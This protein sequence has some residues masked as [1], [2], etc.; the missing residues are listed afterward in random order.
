MM[1]HLFPNS[2]DCAKEMHID[3]ALAQARG[4]GNFQDVEILNEPQKENCPLLF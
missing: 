1:F 4:F 2:S 3:G